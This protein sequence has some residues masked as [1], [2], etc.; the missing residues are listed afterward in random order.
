MIENNNRETN[1]IQVWPDY[2]YTESVPEELPI[3]DEPEVLQNTDGTTYTIQKAKKDDLSDGSTKYFLM[4]VTNLLLVKEFRQ[5]NIYRFEDEELLRRIILPGQTTYRGYTPTFEVDGTPIEYS[6]IDPKYNFETCQI[7]LNTKADK[8]Y[9][10]CWIYIGATL[11]DSYKPPFP[12]DIYL[13]INNESQAKAKIRLLELADKEYYLPKANME[14]QVQKDGTLVTH[15]TINTVI[16]EIGEIDG[17]RY[18]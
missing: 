10:T 11:A 18:W 7:E 4:K 3:L 2:V 9:I 16:N 6:V 5:K 13:L 17:G 12:D 8:V 14:G 15:E 1:F